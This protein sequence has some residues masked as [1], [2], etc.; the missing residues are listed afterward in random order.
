MRER[1]HGRLSYSNVL[2]TILAVV[3]LGNGIADAAGH[4][5]KNSVGTK[6]LKKNSVTTAKVKKNA[7]T[8]AKVKG[9]TLTGS[10]INLKKLGTVPSAT[11]AASA[12]SIPP[13]EP[14]HIV[15][16]PGEPGFEGGSENYPERINGISYPPVGFYKD[17]FGIVHLEGVATVRGEPPV[18]F[19]LPPGYRPASGTQQIFE[20]TKEGGVLILGSPVEGVGAGAIVALK[21][22][23]PLSGVTYRAGS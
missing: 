23:V 3:V 4:L 16:A 10:D 20:T 13:A 17:A 9:H 1:N 11:H 15:G 8:G 6:Q 7:V 19:T 22:N 21:E 2:V 5:G 12:D 18:I 14:T